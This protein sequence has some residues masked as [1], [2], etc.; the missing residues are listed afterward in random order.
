MDDLS[1]CPD[2]RETFAMVAVWAWIAGSPGQF[3]T[4][5][6]SGMD[7]RFGDMCAAQKTAA[8]PIAEFPKL[9]RSPQS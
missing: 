6:N 3:H 8:R 9:A 2:V 1:R 4:A 7:G 5:V